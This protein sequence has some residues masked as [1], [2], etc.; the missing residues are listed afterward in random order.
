MNISKKNYDEA[1]SQLTIVANASKQTPLTPLALSNLAFAYEENGDPL[2]AALTYQRFMDSYS[3]HFLAP[4]VQLSLGRAYA[5]AGET[6]QAQ[7]SLEQLI[8]LY[9]TSP[10]SENA[11]RILDKLESR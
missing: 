9:P 11:R 5:D 8:D 2:Q 7:A 6:V 1:I 4:H 10:W 3:E